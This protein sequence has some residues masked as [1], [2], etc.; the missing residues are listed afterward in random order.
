MSDPELHID[1]RTGLPEE[2]QFLLKRYPRDTWMANTDLGETTKFWLSIH[3]H[4][5]QMAAHLTSVSGDYREGLVDA[6]AFRTRM[7]PRLQQF[8]GTLDHHHRIEDHHFFPHFIAAEERLAR[9]IELLEA[10]HHTIDAQVHAM[11]ASA[12]ALLQTPDGDKDALKRN[13]ALFADTSD[14]IVTLLG[15][16]LDDEEDIVVPLMLDRGEVELLS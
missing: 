9:G 4:F 6:N 11:V 5:R 16:H 10:D 15:R 8:L 2:W 12:N 14:R 1:M 7:A 3:R 13:G